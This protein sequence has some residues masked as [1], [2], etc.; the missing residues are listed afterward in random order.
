MSVGTDRMSLLSYLKQ[1][2]R[3]FFVNEIFILLDNDLSIKH[4]GLTEYIKIHVVF[5]VSLLFSSLLILLNIF[6]KA[7]LNFKNLIA[8]SRV[9]REKNKIR[10]VIGN[11]QYISDDIKNKDYSIYRYGSRRKRLYF[12]FFLLAKQSFQEF[13]YIKE[14]LNC[15]LL[16]ENKY[17]ILS[18]CA[19][20]IPHTVVF[21]NTINYVIS[22][23]ELTDIYIGATH[24]RFALIIEDEAKK[25]N[26]RIICIPHGVETTDEF[27]HEYVGDIFYCTSFNV[28][29]KLKEVYKSNKYIYDESVTKRMFQIESIPTRKTRRVVFFTSPLRNE[30]NTK[31]IIRETALFLKNMNEKLFIKVHPI[32]NSKD[33]LFYNCE[34]VDNFDEAIFGNI[35]VSFISTALIEAIYN[36]SVAISITNLVKNGDLLDGNRYFLNDSRII[37]P[38]SWDEYISEFEKLRNVELQ[39]S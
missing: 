32:E 38:E 5:V 20:R 35:C 13:N 29:V 37:K 21:K 28:S 1:N 10:R 9:S 11:A 24:E 19:K 17:L 25:Y 22:H 6:F 39:R 30:E 15:D 23:Y 16:K 34:I 31:E 14:I 4:W 26:K 8:I 7:N 36:E 27:P 3:S 12:L 33:Y 2:N 18:W